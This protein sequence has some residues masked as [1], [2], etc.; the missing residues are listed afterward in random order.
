MSEAMNVFDRRLVRWHRDR[1][2]RR[3]ANHDFLLR[4]VAERLAD[5]LDDV[6]RSFARALDL[7]CH[8]GVLAE[9]LAGRGGVETLVQCDFG[10]AMA[11]AAKCNG[12]PTLAADEECLPFADGSFDLVLSVLSLHWVNDLPGALIQIQRALKPDG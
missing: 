8:G 6:R 2:A 1:A 3:A 11:G 12:Y 5:R 7:G 4:E 9:I 10:P